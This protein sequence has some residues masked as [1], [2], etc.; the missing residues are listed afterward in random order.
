MVIGVG[1]QHV[2]HDSPPKL[3]QVRGRAGGVIFDGLRDFQVA[4]LLAVARSKHCHRADVADSSSGLAVEAAHN[5][6]RT[7]G[8]E[9]QLVRWDRDPG[10]VRE[11]QRDLLPADHVPPIAGGRGELRD[12]KAL[13]RVEDVRLGPGAAERARSVQQ[14]PEV[15]GGRFVAFELFRSA[16]SVAR[17]PA[18]APRRAA[19]RCRCS[20]APGRRSAARGC[21]G[22]GGCAAGSPR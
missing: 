3:A 6:H 7:A 5:Q 9:V 8:D 16:A 2:E 11:R 20:S 21:R 13:H 22:R 4:A 19:C 10:F 18:D 17:G 12:R 15:L 14:Q 1:D